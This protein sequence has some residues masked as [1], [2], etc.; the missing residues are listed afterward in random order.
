MLFRRLLA[1]SS[2]L[3]LA[4]CAKTDANQDGQTPPAAA[5]VAS[6]ATP[7]SSA[8]TPG[9]TDLERVD[10]ARQKGSATSPVWFIMASD[11]QCPFCRT[12]H[13][14]VWP[15]IEREYVATGKIRVAFMNH[16]MAFHALGIPAAEAAMCAGA[17]D[18]F[19]PMHDSLFVNQDK[20][21][22]GG[23]A[24]A[25]FESLATSI[26]LNMEAWKQC[27]STH[28]TK[29]MVELDFSRTSQAGVTGTPSFVIGG[30][31]AVVGAEPYAS[32]KQAIDAA[33]ARAGK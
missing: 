16:P 12:F 23:R 25:V 31:L 3:A 14:E 24:Q 8:A 27:V 11:F 33:I 30:Q 2:L 4:A 21:A 10:K 28:A 26:G 22:K 20:W 5:T 9:S 17:Q 18:K 1:A 32:F 19:W 15:R 6:A 29:A 13:H 7:A